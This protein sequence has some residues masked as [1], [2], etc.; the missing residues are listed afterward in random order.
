M[1]TYLCPWPEQSGNSQTAL[2]INANRADLQLPALAKTER[3]QQAKSPASSHEAWLQGSGSLDVS[4]A[5][6]LMLAA[7]R[8]HACRPAQSIW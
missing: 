4:R 6:V 7:Q 1:A 3:Q 2:L 8:A 5:F